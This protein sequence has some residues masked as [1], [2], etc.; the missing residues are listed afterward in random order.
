[1]QANTVLVPL[2]VT[3]NGYLLDIGDGRLVQTPFTS[4][5]TVEPEKTHSK[6]AS[7]TKGKSAKL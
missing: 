5:K 7:S 4:V 1:L 6:L 2:A 3:S